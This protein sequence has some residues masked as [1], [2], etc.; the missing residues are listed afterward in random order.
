MKPTKRLRLGKRGGKRGGKRARM[1]SGFTRVHP[2]RRKFLRSMCGSNKKCYMKSVRRI[3]STRRRMLI[4]FKRK[5]QGKKRCI[6]GQIKN[7]RK[8]FY[9]TRNV[10]RKACAKA[11]GSK[12]RSC[13]QGRLMAYEGRALKTAMKGAKMRGR[14]GKKQT[15]KM[16]VAK[17]AAKKVT[18]KAKKA[19]KKASVAG[20]KAARSPT[21]AN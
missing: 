16:K 10:A 11:K 15:R 3:Y 18:K 5:C 21:K 13:E 20:V 7:F 2:I 12:K 14:G 19:A 17:N 9:K 8:I 1:F 4:A 6:F